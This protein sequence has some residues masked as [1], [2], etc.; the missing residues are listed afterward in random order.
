MGLTF[1]A[2]GCYRALCDKLIDTMNQVMDTFYKEAISGL[3]AQGKAATEVEKAKLEKGDLT[4]G[5]A[6]DFIVT[7]AK[8]YADAIME[9]Y[10]TGS[11]ADTG[12]RSYWNEYMQSNL[13]NP[14]RPGKPIYGRPKGEY[15][16]IYGEQ[17]SSMGFYEGVNL[18]GVAF[19][20]L[21]KIEPIS[22]SMSIQHAEDWVIKNGETRVERYLEIAINDFFAN[23]AKNFFVYV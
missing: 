15:T 7:K 4:I 20:G 12:P 3:S 5:N 8:F 2:D 17:D 23:E 16:N 6:S 11:K 10:G 19:S 14:S 22:P 18:E 13:F 1:D 21:K 9:S